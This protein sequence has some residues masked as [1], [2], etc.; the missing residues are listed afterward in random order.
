[1]AKCKYNGKDVLHVTLNGRSLSLI[2]GSEFEVAF[3]KGKPNK[4]FDKLVSDKK[5]EVLDGDLYVEPEKKDNP[6]IIPNGDD[7]KPAEPT[8]AAPAAPA[9]PAKPAVQ[10]PAKPA[11]EG[12]GKPGEEKK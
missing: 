12:D 5:V 3:E 6:K 11:A 2:P 1:M 10:Q 7:Q 8:A 4:Y 9:Q